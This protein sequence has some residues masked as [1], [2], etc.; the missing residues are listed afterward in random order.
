MPPPRFHSF[1]PPS[2]FTLGGGSSRGTKLSCGGPELLV[3]CGRGQRH[4]VG[5]SRVC[6][7]CACSELLQDVRLRL[8]NRSGRLTTGLTF[9]AELGRESRDGQITPHPQNIRL[10]Q[11]EFSA[12]ETANKLCSTPS[13]PP[14]VLPSCSFKKLQSQECG[15]HLPIPRR[16]MWLQMLHGTLPSLK[17][18]LQHCN[19]NSEAG[20][21]GAL[22]REVGLYRAGST[23][24]R[25]VLDCFSSV[26]FVLDR[27]P[28]LPR[29]SL[30]PSGV[31]NAPCMGKKL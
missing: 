23:H 19:Q 26:Q 25:R 20:A 18:F 15:I 30:F 22:G 5:W 9:P 11:E 8:V 16:Q 14:S 13:F 17:P 3:G 7:V 4:G 21:V 12:G 6:S 31:L 24:F 29:P 28:S 1:L 27:S 2:R 10:F